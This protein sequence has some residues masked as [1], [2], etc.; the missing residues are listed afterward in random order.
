LFFSYYILFAK[1]MTGTRAL[2][3]NGGLA[4]YKK[5]RKEFRQTW[6]FHRLEM[7]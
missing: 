2:T 4:I 7:N 1:N 5:S 3:D 6:F